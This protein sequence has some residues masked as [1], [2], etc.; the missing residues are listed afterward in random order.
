MART[1]FNAGRLP[2]PSLLRWRCCR[3][4]CAFRRQSVVH[5]RRCRWVFWIDRHRWQ[6]VI[7]L[8]RIGRCA[9]TFHWRLRFFWHAWSDCR[10]L[11]T[12][13]RHIG[14]HPQTGA[15]RR[16]RRHRLVGPIDRVRSAASPHY[17]AA[18]CLDAHRYRASPGL[19]YQDDAQETTD[20]RHHLASPDRDARRRVGN[21]ASP[22]QAYRCR[23]LRAPKPIQF[24][25][26]YLPPYARDCASSKTRLRWLCRH[27]DCT[28]DGTEPKRQIREAD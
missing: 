15:W 22:D 4:R 20:V 18:D 25:T 9:S 26:C 12:F 24:V 14:Y 23:R 21:P 11:K 1:I 17:R 16:A 6:G 3:R 19:V 13:A 5:D 2:L 10:P 8:S 27:L 28:A 7:R